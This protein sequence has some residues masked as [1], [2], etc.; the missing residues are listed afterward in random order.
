MSD[1]TWEDELCRRLHSE[2][3]ESCR[4]YD[5]RGD[6]QLVSFIR[7]TIKDE[8]ARALEEVKVEKR[9]HNHKHWKGQVCSEGM[10]GPICDND[11][12]DEWNA[13]VDAMEK[14]KEKIL[15]NL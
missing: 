3:Y 15:S 6:E 5:S 13:A 8:V 11:M 12:A 7:S 14:K 4:D 2:W 1:P 9:R 10:V